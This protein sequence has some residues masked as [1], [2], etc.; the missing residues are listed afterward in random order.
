MHYESK[1]E[2]KFV[3]QPPLAVYEEPSS[4]SSMRVSSNPAYG[5]I[6]IKWNINVILACLF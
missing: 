1:Q 3:K 2:D 4:S 5:Q 6:N